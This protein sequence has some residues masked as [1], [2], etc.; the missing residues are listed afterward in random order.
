M[1]EHLILRDEAAGDLLACAAFLAE[2]IGGSDDRAEA[3]AAVVPHYLAKGNVDL[4][5]ELANTV[6]DPFVRDRLLIA[7]AA[8]CA[9]IDDDEYSLQLAE[10]IEEYGLQSQAREAIALTKA[11]KGDFETARAVAD[12][13]IHPDHV[14]GGIAIRQAERGDEAAALA[15]IAEID[16]AGSSTMAF[17]T[18]AAMNV[19]KGESEKAAEYLETAA[20]LAQE[21]EHDEEKI[22][23]LVDVGNLYHDAGRSDKAIETLDRARGFAEEL[24]NVHRDSLLSAVSQGFMRSGSVDLADRTL[25]AVTDKT[26]IATAL[27]GF[28]REY[29]RK[30]EKD[31]AFEALEEAYDVLRSQHEKE[32]R[33]SK[34]KYSLFGTIAAQFAGF[35]RGERA[36]EIAEG[37]ED[38]EH[39]RAA[40]GQIARIL[41]SQEHTELARQALNAIDEGA[42]RM[43]AL[44][45]MSDAAKEKE[46]SEEAIGLLNEA[47]EL[48]DEVPQMSARATAFGEMIGR[49]VV[50]G[51][52]ERGREI[53]TLNLS[54]ITQIRG[55][56]TKAIALANLSEVVEK[57]EFTLTDEDKALV[58]QMLVPKTF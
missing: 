48:A 16:Y 33:D 37:I 5:A 25:D 41:T 54:T 11:A 4:A 8:K 3:I 47:V 43:F 24:D 29:W 14:L 2:E 40:L 42:N 39:A 51:E 23:A 18:M 46:R 30:E 35:D 1:A 53:A 9:E 34:A 45:G 26:Q 27:L 50:L 36:I 58:R 17:L 49:F 52:P 19:D 38:D 13:V 6:D 31:E 10:A 55:E 28:A 56:S 57:A 20:V 44:T 15:T 32:T 22:R 12:S 7:V 21:I